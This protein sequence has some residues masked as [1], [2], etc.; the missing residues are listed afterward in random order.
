[1]DEVMV[2]NENIGD[3]GADH[4]TEAQECADADRSR[5]QQ[6]DGRD[7]LAETREDTE[8]LANANRVEQLNHLFCAGKFHARG[9]QEEKR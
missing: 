1:M 4:D 2:Q 6:E 7:K 9:H 3:C 8:P 5:K